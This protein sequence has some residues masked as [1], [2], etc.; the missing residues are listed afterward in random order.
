MKR[1]RLERRLLNRYANFVDNDKKI[2]LHFVMIL[3]SRISHFFQLVNQFFVFILFLRGTKL[4]QNE[5]AKL[6]LLEKLKA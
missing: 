5:N 4:Y 6:N 2:R 1:K 3:L